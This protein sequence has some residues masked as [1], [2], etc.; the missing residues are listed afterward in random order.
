[1]AYDVFESKMNGLAKA[2]GTEVSCRTYKGNHRAKFS[3]GTVIFANNSSSKISVRW[4][5]GHE[6]YASVDGNLL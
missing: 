6:A 2:S 5:S 3:D 1:M 4:G